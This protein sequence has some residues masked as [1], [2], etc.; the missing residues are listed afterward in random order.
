[1][2]SYVLVGRSTR[3]L[4]SDDLEE[5]NGPFHHERRQRS[6][7]E[8]VRNHLPAMGSIPPVD[9]NAAHQVEEHA[10]EEEDE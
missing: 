6:P 2:P 10:Q 3:G 1:M 8:Q 5:E 9:H 7:E 4:A